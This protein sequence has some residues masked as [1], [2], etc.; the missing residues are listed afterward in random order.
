M[1]INL[2]G[3]SGYM[4]G[5]KTTVARAIQYITEKLGRKSENFRYFLRDVEKL[6][7]QPEW[8]LKGFSHKL[9][10]IASLLTGIPAYKFEDQ[11][12]KKSFL[13][14]E[15]NYMYSHHIDMQEEEF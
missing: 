10:E 13:G 9:K 8:E 6:G 1:S 11:E 14:D 15:W 12:F 3:I 7:Y 4:E 5:G 2:I